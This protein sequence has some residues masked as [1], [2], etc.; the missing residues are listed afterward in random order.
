[1][2]F[3]IVCGWE[4]CF[5]VSQGG[6]QKARA[7]ITRSLKQAVNLNSSFPPFQTQLHI[8][9]RLMIR[10]NV[11]TRNTTFLLTLPTT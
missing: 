9:Q 8:M 2:G 11:A 1:M 4:N 5:Y 7:E 10:N 6:S 3:D